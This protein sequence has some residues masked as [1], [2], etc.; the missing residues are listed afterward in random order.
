MLS[1]AWAAMSQG[2]T[3]LRSSP[4]P[5]QEPRTQITATV[6]LVRLNVAV[7][8]PPGLPV[9]PL[10][11][12][13]FKVYDND[14]QQD[15]ELIW[16]P[17]DMPVHVALVFD[18]SPSV[19][20]WRLS[21]RR[22]A[23]TF[24]LKLSPA[25]CPYVLPFSD[26]VGPGRWGRYSTNEWT[27]FLA[28]VDPGSGTSLHDALLFALYQ[29]D[30][31]DEIAAE[32]NVE[33]D[34][35]P[36]AEQDPEPATPK[37]D[38]EKTSQPAGMREVPIKVTRAMLMALISENVTRMV[39]DFTETQVGNCDLRGKPGK[40]TI[41]A[42]LLLSDGADTSSDASFDTVMTAARLA[43]VPVFPVLLGTAGNDPELKARLSQIAS[44]TGGL[45]TPDVAPVR[46]SAAYND[47][48]AYLRSTY[49]LSYTP[50]DSASQK[51]E[52][53]SRATREGAAWHEVRVELRR[54]LLRTIVRPGYYR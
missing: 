12:E 41:K 34:D 14:T 50:T 6:E 21:V 5:S 36:P 48:L 2:A 30:L 1:L 3:S 46:L 26:V 16:R 25:D 37:H 8:A 54:P 49:I 9:P 42:I 40:G 19:R 10:T 11:V 7:L 18:M 24:L 31:A 17:T 51:P 22:A 32:A 4:N 45:L 53:Q 28:H 20:P 23:L 47:V 44:A 52:D 13:D 27:N 39:P 29:L 15:I 33:P 38:G 43:N 35:A